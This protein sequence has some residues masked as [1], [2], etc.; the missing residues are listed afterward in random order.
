[1]YTNCGVGSAAG[2]AD[3]ADAM[4]DALFAHLSCSVD[5]HN[6]KVRCTKS[7]VGCVWGKGMTWEGKAST[8]SSTHFGVDRVRLYQSMVV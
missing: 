4:T 1:M 6:V 7:G 5:R 3:A 8:L 2:A